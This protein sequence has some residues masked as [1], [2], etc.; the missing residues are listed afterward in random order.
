MI[1]KLT[2]SIMLSPGANATSP[3]RVK[4][5]REKILPATRKTRRDFARR[6]SR[7]RRNWVLVRKRRALVTA[8]PKLKR[9]LRVQ[10]RRGGKSSF[11]SRFLDPS[12]YDISQDGTR[13]IQSRLIL[14]LLFVY[15][16]D[17]CMRIFRLCRCNST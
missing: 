4:M 2:Y 15:R 1:N 12:N 16:T 7:E 14:Q 6:Y 8:L 10:A 11:I 13:W 5:L 17:Q 3:W 9:H